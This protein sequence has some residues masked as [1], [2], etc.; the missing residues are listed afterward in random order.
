[1][2]NIF[3]NDKVYICSKCGSD[4]VGTEFSFYGYYNEPYQAPSC[5][6]LTHQDSDWCYDCD[7]AVIVIEKE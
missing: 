1:M 5:G 3:G 6:Q 4:N 7:E 2:T